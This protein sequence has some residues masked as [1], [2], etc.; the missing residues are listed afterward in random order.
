MNNMFFWFKAYTVRIKIGIWLKSIENIA[1]YLNVHTHIH[2]EKRKIIL[3]W[4]LVFEVFEIVD[5]II[6]EGY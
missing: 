1:L 4:D 3:C 6:E 2:S 5:E